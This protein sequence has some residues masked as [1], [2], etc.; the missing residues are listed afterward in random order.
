MTRVLSIGEAMVEMAPSAQAGE[1]RMGF[2]GD[3]MNT[4]WYLRRLLPETDAVDYLTAVGTDA[5]S[6]QM[7]AFLEAAGIGTAH[8]AR[9]PDLTVGLYMIQLQDGERSFSY[10]RGQSAA[11]TLA[12]DARTLTQAMTGADIT[13]FSGITL[14]ILPRDDRQRLLDALR[15]FRAQGAEV[16]FDPN[17]RPR[18]WVGP[19]QMTEAVM[20]A[21]AVSDTILPS[22]EDEA[23]WFGD[24]DPLETA[25][26]Y[27]GAGARMVIVKNGPGRILAWAEGKTS[28]HDP[29]PVSDIVDT[30]A[31]GDAFN[32]GFLAGRIAGTPLAQSI[33]A[34]AA[35]S[36]KVI[37]S[38]G[39]LVS[40]IL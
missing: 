11:R 21:A 10:W 26:R 20:Q 34:A 40:S 3:T 6:D 16:V 12:E 18:L 23:T 5:V 33:H 38:R 7:V 15:G 32:A 37:Q 4:A 39:A 9:R 27:A 31:A 25:K 8:V 1:Y 28:R 13:Y 36:A 24:A 29:V 2:A 19:A 35:L 14:A 22:H 30:T 17:L